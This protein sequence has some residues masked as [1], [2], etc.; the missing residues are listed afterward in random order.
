MRAGVQRKGEYH[1]LVMLSGFG[2]GVLMGHPGNKI[3]IVPE[4]GKSIP[5]KGNSLKVC[6]A[7]TKS[8]S[9]SRIWERYLIRDGL[10]H[11]TFVEH[12][13]CARYLGYRERVVNMI[14]ISGFCGGLLMEKAN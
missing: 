9:L 4:E 8:L 11:P 3:V 2:A 5:G 7:K 10:L 12:L 6:L 14:G 1:Q 13:L